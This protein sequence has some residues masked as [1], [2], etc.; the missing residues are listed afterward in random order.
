MNT[1]R[2]MAASAKAWI[3]PCKILVLKPEY[4]VHKR[5]HTKLDLREVSGLE[6]SWGDP[7]PG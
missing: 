4:P 2:K 5:W 1:P 6:E 3:T 7:R